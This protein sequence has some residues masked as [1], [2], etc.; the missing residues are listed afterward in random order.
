MQLS[1][2]LKD[3]S[4]RG[5]VVAGVRRVPFPKV[6]GALVGNNET[7]GAETESSQ[8]KPEQERPKPTLSQ[9]QFLSWKRHKDAAVS[10][11]KA[12]VSSKRAEDI[13]AG[14]V[15]MNGRELFLHEPWVF[16]NSRY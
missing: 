8:E 3:T 9:E 5:L 7:M 4:L 10:A 13:A 2:R 14:T 12:E 11:R 1:E 6:S 16:D 15:Q